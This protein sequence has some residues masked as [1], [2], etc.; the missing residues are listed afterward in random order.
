MDQPNYLTDFQ[1]E[2]ARIFFGLKAT[3]CYLV[4]GGAALPRDP[5]IRAQ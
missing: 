2:V 4:T 5:P 3:D 1:V